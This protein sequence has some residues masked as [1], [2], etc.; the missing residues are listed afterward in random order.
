MS[1]GKSVAVVLLCVTVAGHNSPRDRSPNHYVAP[2]ASGASDGTRERPWDL[3]TALGG[4]GGAIQSGDTVWLLGGTYRGAFRT[5]L[6][7]GPNRYIVFRQLPGARATIDG[8]LRADGSYLAFWGFE[9]RQSDPV[10]AGTYGLQAN[11]NAGRF[12]NLIIHDVG[13]Q[14]VSFWT[15]GV[16]GELYGCIVYNNG[17]HANLDHGVYAHNE[18]G[19]KRLT[20][21]VFFNNFARGI[22]IY[23][24]PK[25]PALNNF[26]VDGNVSFN[27]GT[28]AGTAGRY[29]LLISAEVPTAGMVATNNMLYYSPG[30]AGVNIRLGHYAAANNR[31]IVL[32][33]NYAGGGRLAL[34]MDQP[35]NQAAVEQNVFI[36]DGEMVR[37]AATGS[38]R[39]RWSDNRY[40]RDPGARAWRYGGT[41]ATFADW[42]RVTGL[43]GAG[44]ALTAAPE[45]RV[46]VR[47]NQYEAGRATI[48]VYN[49]RRAAKVSVD[50]ASVLRPGDEFELHN[51]QALFDTPV[52]SGTYRG[53]S[54]VIPMTGVAPPP[55]TGRPA[56]RPPRTG[57][58]FDTF[59]LTTRPR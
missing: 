15:P 54:L 14:G 26:V 10:G 41:A 37:V 55:P 9:I 45:S 25:N 52:L 11:T 24:S 8:T 46:F 38:K 27:N 13:T 53:D 7:G 40:Y 28:I 5:T 43:G 17:S 33:G 23:A 50:V 21:N 20:D 47:P 32:R 31:D 49:W 58:L 16:D 36:G 44:D 48:I 4:A 2:T 12:I 6:A 51:V 39:Y 30:A 59:L 22:Q 29:N 42:R 57:P 19:T 1:A 34:E 18:I 3:A 56:A 35:W